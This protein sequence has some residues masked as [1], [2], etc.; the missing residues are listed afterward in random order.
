[1]SQ[2]M[3]IIKSERWAYG[4]SL[5]N[6]FLCMLENINDKSFKKALLGSLQCFWGISF[7]VSG[8]LFLPPFSWHSVGDVMF[9]T[10]ME[11]AFNSAVS[12][13]WRPIIVPSFKCPQSFA[14]NVYSLSGTKF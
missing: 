8:I 13:R 1:M 3:V 9:Y 14:N 10:Q 4:G 5:Y 2:I 7:G 6:L 11:P 12:Q